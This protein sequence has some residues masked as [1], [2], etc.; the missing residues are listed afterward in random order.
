MVLLLYLRSVAIAG[1]LV[2]A[3]PSF[4]GADVA[5]IDELGLQRYDG[6]DGGRCWISASSSSAPM[7]PDSKRCWR[8][9]V[10]PI[11][12]AMGMSS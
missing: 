9:V 2:Y 5:R 11:G 12:S 3:R 4:G 7:R 10:R 1:G 6:R 8:I